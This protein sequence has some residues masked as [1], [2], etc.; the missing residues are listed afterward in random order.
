MTIASHPSGRREREQRGA[1]PLRLVGDA[2]D[3]LAG[4][5]HLALDLHLVRVEIHEAALDA[6]PPRAE[7]APVEASA[8][9]DARREVADDATSPQGGRRRR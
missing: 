9:Q 5:G 8:A 1:A 3:A 6:D 7:E 2:D 4:G